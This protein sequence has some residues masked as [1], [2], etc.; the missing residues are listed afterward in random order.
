M[1]ALAGIPAVFLALSIAFSY[2]SPRWLMKVSRVAEARTV[3]TLMN[4]SRAGAEEGEAI[5]KALSEEKG[6]W[7]E[8][9]SP[10]VRPALM[11]GFVLAAF[12]Q[13]SGIT[14]LLSFLPEVFRSAGQKSN[15]AFVQSILVGIINLLFTLLD[16]AC[17][18]P[19]RQGRTEDIASHRYRHPVN[20]SRICRSALFQQEP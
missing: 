10:A 3:I 14:A 8:L 6:S 11:V 2:E 13:A 9:F 5:R 18:Y 12:S 16:P 7:A 15:D 20:R 17:D 4:G 1:F 19:G